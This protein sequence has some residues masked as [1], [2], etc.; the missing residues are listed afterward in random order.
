MDTTMTVSSG[1]EAIVSGLIAHGV[2]TVFGLPGAQIYGLF[3]A[4]QQAQL[5]VIGARHEQACGYMAYGYARSTGRPGVFSVVPGPGVLNAGAALL[6]AYGANEPV[7]CLT[8]QVP[9]ECLG[10]GRGHLHEMPDQ[11]ATLR[12]FVKWADRA[13]YPDVAPTLVARA[14]QEMLSG[15]R[16]PAA[17]EMPW[18][19]FTQRTDAEAVKPFAPFPAPQPDSDRSCKA[20]ALIMAAKAPM[21]FVGSGALHA[22]E[23]IQELAEMIAA[24]VVAFRSGRGIV[25]NAHE[26]GD[27]MAAAYKLWPQT[28]LMIGIGTRMEL[29]TS[30]RWPFRPV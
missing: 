12:T 23:E 13:E 18:D 25:S 19:V 11:L 30:F 20:A 17:I 2:D 14:F 24:P 4:F 3:D 1:G 29:S 26:L 21:I 27:T 6:T 22:R 7:L 8:G 28:D 16:G 5:K 15:R 10:K 9:T